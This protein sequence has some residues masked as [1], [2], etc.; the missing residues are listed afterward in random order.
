MISPAD[1]R[2]I[3]ERWKTATR[4]LKVQDQKYGL[5]LAEMI[6]KYNRK[7]YERFNEPLEVA[8]FIILMQLVKGER[9]NKEGS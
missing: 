8:A 3:S 4:P 2:I 9:M 6:E 7:E 1:M 5:R